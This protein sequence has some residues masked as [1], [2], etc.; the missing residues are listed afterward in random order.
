M[1]RHLTNTHDVAVFV[2]AE[3]LKI[4][5][6]AR[7]D[8]RLGVHTGCRRLSGPSP[9]L[10]RQ[11]ITGA[12]SRLERM[13]ATF[14]YVCACQPPRVDED[15]GDG[16]SPSLVVGE[17]TVHGGLQAFNGASV[18]CFVKL[19]VVVNLGVRYRSM[20]AV[21]VPSLINSTWGRRIERRFG[22]ECRGGST[23]SA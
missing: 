1:K 23:R 14:F 11:S 20:S 16:G 8:F 12:S 22:C 9:K 2:T 5:Q 15:G 17:R 18:V 4:K 3:R 19:D 13:E 6:N 7:F 21:I 10:R